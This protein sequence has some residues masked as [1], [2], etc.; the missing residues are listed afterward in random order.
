MVAKSLRTKQIGLAGIGCCAKITARNPS[1]GSLFLPGAS[2]AALS[3]GNYCH[4]SGRQA[5]M[6][7]AI[8]LVITLQRLS[9]Q[10][11]K[12]AKMLTKLEQ[13]MAI[14]ETIFQGLLNSW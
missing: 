3:S 4:A 12:K 9:L 1:C 5:H 7:P 8:Q 6:Q 13:N 2:S 14:M 10:K 11:W